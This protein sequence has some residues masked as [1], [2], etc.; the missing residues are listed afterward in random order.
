MR[1][2]YTRPLPGAEV[3]D[4]G[5]GLGLWE[6]LAV[7]GDL[8]DRLT[9]SFEL[10]VHK[11]R[12]RWLC[13]EMRPRDASDLLLSNA[14][15]NQVKVGDLMRQAIRENLHQRTDKGWAFPAPPDAIEAFIG[16]LPRRRN[17]ATPSRLETA[18]K[19]FE[20]GGIEEVAATLNV[21][22]SQAYRLVKKGKAR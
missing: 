14:E 17:E 22:R 11:R 8:G 4:V 16:S 1:L 19:A 10:A 7:Q 2:T 9:V 3:V 15:L 5:D 6:E 21:S 13:F 12:I 20:R 18:T